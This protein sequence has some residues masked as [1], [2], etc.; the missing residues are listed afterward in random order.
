MVDKHELQLSSISP[1]GDFSKRIMAEVKKHMPV[2]NN[3]V[4]GQLVS[5]KLEIK[6]LQEELAKLP[7]LADLEQSIKK[8]MQQSKL[9]ESTASNSTSVTSSTGSRSGEVDPT[10]LE[11]LKKRDEFFE[12]IIAN[13]QAE[14][15]IIKKSLSNLNLEMKL[16]P[17]ASSSCIMLK[18]QELLKARNKSDNDI[19]LNE[20]KPA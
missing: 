11:L 4:H 18:Y 7:R 13:I 3:D 2:N 12:G 20:C 8:E 10:L 19:I 14:V 5:Q 9:R 16:S 6:Q 17:T 1:E 15:S